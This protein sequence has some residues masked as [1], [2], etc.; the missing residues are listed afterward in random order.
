MN[1][2]IMTIKLIGFYFGF[3]YDTVSSINIDR[4]MKLR[5]SETIH[6]LLEI[7]RKLDK[8]ESEINEAFQALI[9]EYDLREDFYDNQDSSLGLH[10]ICHTGTNPDS[11]QFRMMEVFHKADRLVLAHLVI[12][13]DFDVNG[14]PGTEDWSDA[15]IQDFYYN[16]FSEKDRWEDRTRVVFDKLKNMSKPLMFV[17]VSDVVPIDTDISQRILDIDRLHEVIIEKSV[18]HE[19]IDQDIYEIIRLQHELFKRTNGKW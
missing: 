9:A 8:F 10:P 13:E 1:I 17:D 11:I 14:I 15:E 5:P 18:K 19:D 16:F 2:V 12:M 7:K 4:A 3:L 6:I